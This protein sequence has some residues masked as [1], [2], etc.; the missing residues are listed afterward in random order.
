MAVNSRK[1]LRALINTQVKQANAR[2]ELLY[3]ANLDGVSLADYV[4]ASMKNYSSLLI[5]KDAQ[6][7]RLFSELSDNTH[8]TASQLTERLKIVQQFNTSSRF[9]PQ[10]IIKDA[11]HRAESAGLTPG[12][13]ATFWKL[14]RDY[15]FDYVG[16]SETFVT[17]AE[18]VTAVQ[19]N[20]VLR[21]ELN[22]AKR[23]ARQESALT[24]ESFDDLYT[25]KQ[26]DTIRRLSGVID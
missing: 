23:L 3:G 14:A 18:Q 26:R 17:L 8:M 5:K 25:E 15:D 13:F 4:S 21:K 19:G 6:G 10:S 16:D 1:F 9:D 12:E 7:N 2:L 24:G 20:D 11:R 22:K